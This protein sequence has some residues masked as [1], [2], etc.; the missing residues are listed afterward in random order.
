M[1][2]VRERGAKSCLAS[3]ASTQ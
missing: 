2:V 1:A 3:A